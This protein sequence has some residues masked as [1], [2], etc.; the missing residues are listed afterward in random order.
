MKVKQEPSCA[1]TIYIAGDR[2]DAARLLRG[3]CMSGAC[4]TVTATDFIYTGGMESGVA[5]GLVNYPRFPATPKQLMDR[6]TGIAVVMMEG[7]YQHSALVVGP[8]KTVWM[9]KRDD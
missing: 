6:A 5:V 2:A 4:V 9:T 3:Y 8:E 1:V 7:L